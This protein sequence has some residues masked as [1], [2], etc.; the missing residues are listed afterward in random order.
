M[1][2]FELEAD[3][4]PLLIIF[5]S[6]TVKNLLSSQLQQSKNFHQFLENSKF[7]A[8]NVYR[9]NIIVIILCD[10]KTAWFLTF[11][12]IFK[13]FR[14]SLKLKNQ[15]ASPRKLIPLEEAVKRLKKKTIIRLVPLIRWKSIFRIFNLLINNTSFCHK[16]R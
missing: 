6:M 8:C 1:S 4:I 9:Y 15:D 7:Q 14:S 11:M 2:W 16:S 3:G 5:L 12:F 13:I 10:F